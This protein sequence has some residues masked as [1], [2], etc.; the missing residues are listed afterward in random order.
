MAANSIFTSFLEGWLIRQESFFQELEALLSPVDGFD[1]NLECSKIIPRVF[2]HYQ[3]FYT[4]KA[5]AAG[6]DAFLLISPPWLSSFEKSLLWISGFRPSMLF[7]II[8]RS[9]AEDLSAEQKQRIE[10]V[11]SETRR[12]EREFTQAMARIQETVA[13]PPLYGLMMSY[14]KVVNGE[15]SDI[16]GAME[17]LKAAMMAVVEN[18]DALRGW[19][20]AEVV[21]ILSPVQ[22]VKFLAAVSRFQLQ[23][24]KWGMERDRERGNITTNNN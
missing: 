14:E 18:A 7:P 20:A 1:R 10:A 15:T 8:E 6:G 2:S 9:V 19:T 22:S 16:D 24:R 5:R 17:E 4:E 13:E 21:G 3:E 12:K 23:A 11:R